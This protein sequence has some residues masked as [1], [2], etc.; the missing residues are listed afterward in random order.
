[1]DNFYIKRGIKIHKFINNLLTKKQ[2]RQKKQQTSSS[3]QHDMK[4]KKLAKNL[5][6]KLKDKD[7]MFLWGEKRIYKEMLTGQIDA[8]FKNEK[9]K[10]L[11]LVDWKIT[12]KRMKKIPLNNKYNFSSFKC[13][14]GQ[15]ILQLNIYHYMIMHMMSAAAAAAVT[16]TTTT[17]HDH[18]LIKDYKSVE[19]FIG[20]VVGSNVY[21]VKTPILP[22]SFID[23][24]INNY[25]VSNNNQD[26]VVVV[27]GSSSV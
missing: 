10:Q 11:V 2:N 12:S 20:N 6:K 4:M 23:R 24:I 26:D 1:M 7:W 25:F 16:T 19:I 14:M 5:I 18:N 21:F 17:I 9:K 27:H 8:L 3:A 22:I 13:K 15:T